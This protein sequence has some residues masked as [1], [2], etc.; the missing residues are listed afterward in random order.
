[1]THLSQLVNQYECGP[2]TQI[3]LVFAWRP[4]P[5]PEAHVGRYVPR[6][7]HVS[8]LPSRLWPLLS[9]SLFLVALTVLKSTS[10]MLCG[11]AL[12]WRGAHVFLVMR[13]QFW[14]WG[15]RTAEMKCPSHNIASAVH[16]GP[17]FA[18]LVWTLVSWLR[19]CLPGF[20]PVTVFS[21][22][23]SYCAFWWHIGSHVH[24]SHLSSP[25]KS[26]VFTQIIWNSAWEVYLF[27]LVY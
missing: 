26:R 5:V 22:P 6:S 10:Q 7:R 8:S 11:T 27:S 2:V 3:S 15:R 14:V 9:P 21:F 19:E 23:L 12:I 24:S 17:D 20:L 16:R 25:L 18:L 13:L 1:M 4:P